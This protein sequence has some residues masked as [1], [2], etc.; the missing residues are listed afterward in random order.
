MLKKRKLPKY[1][2]SENMQSASM[3]VNYHVYALRTE[4]QL[5]NGGFVSDSIHV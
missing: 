4:I 2:I 5:R 3:I 1:Q